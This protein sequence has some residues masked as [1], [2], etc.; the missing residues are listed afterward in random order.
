M[1]EETTEPS[2]RRGIYLLPNLFT[3]AA[4]FC[5][6][7]A[8][9]SA[10]NGS[11]LNEP[12]RFEYAAIAIFIAMV[13]DG[14]DG[15]VARMTNTQSDFGAEYDSLADMVSFGVAPAMVMYLWVLNEIGKIGWFAAGWFAA[16][17]YVVM[18]ALRLARFNTQVGVADKN[19][20]QG[21]AS[22]SAAGIMAS[23]VWA[24]AENGIDPT[25]IVWLAF[26]ITL[27]SGLMMVSNFRYSSFKGINFKDKVP[28]ITVVLTVLALAVVAQS[29]AIV[30]FCIFWVYALSGPVMTLRQIYIKRAEKKA[31]QQ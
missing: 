22:P 9:I 18:G 10:I 6:F 30:L 7:Y 16:F 14:L 27:F 12:V 28:F 31:K 26:I 17:I 24:G 5:G 2:R 20:F 8:I 23:T 29:P 11:M 3:T 13:L 15:R 21:L 19:Y 25:N 1:S 4:L